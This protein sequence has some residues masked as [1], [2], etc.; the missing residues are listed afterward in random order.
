MSIAAIFLKFESLVILPVWYAVISAEVT[1]IKLSCQ[2][3]NM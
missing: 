3:N 2:S 1:Y